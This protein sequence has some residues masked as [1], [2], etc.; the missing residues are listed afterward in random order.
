VPDLSPRPNLRDKP[1]T[2]LFPALHKTCMMVGPREFVFLNEKKSLDDVNWN[3]GNASKLWYYNLHYFNDLNANKYQ[4]RKSWHNELFKDWLLNNSPVNGNGWESYPISIRIVNWIK[5]QYSGNFLTNECLQSLAVQV[6]WLSSHLERHLLGNHLFSNGKALVFAGVFFKG[7]EAE[8]WLNQGLKIIEEEISEQIL[9]DGGHF[10]LSPMYHSIILSDILD[11]INIGRPY[12]KLNLLNKIQNIASKML[13]YLDVMTHPDGELAFFNDTAFRE[14]FSKNE[15][16]RYAIRLGINQND[17]YQSLNQV[18]LKN[19]GFFRWQNGPAVLL[20]DV[21]RVGPD[22][23][24]GHGHADTLSFELS[25]KKERV[26]V[27]S[28]ISVYEESQK[29]LYQR[30]T[31]AH[32]TVQ[33]DDK[34]SSEVWKSFRVA[35]RARPFDFHIK[36][37]DQKWIEISCSHDGYKRLK[38]R[39]IHRRTWLLTSNRL[40][41]R[42]QIIG[43]YKSAIA[44]Y[45]LH[46]NIMISK[47][48]LKLTNGL[49]LRVNSEG[50]DYKIVNSKWNPEFGKSIDSHC[51]ELFFE[52]PQASLIFNWD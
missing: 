23:I 14:S 29:R 38:G 26:L 16:A 49:L 33:I 24:P 25:I 4:L 20:A 35:R 31:A 1:Y 11:L 21:G 45:Y 2:W 41:V 32:N 40:I 18:Y 37:A 19:S 47:N 36:H 28:G 22:Y 34:D 27:N 7:D 52:K 15:L 43:T 39:N 10:E 50:G 6:R 51:I 12:F 5:W 9:D 30:G 8:N 3:D 13:S 17:D 42:D 44:R 48:L 46:P